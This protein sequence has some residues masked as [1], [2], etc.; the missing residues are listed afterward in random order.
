MNRSLLASVS[1]TWWHDG[2]GRN[3]MVGMH[4]MKI[5]FVDWSTVARAVVARYHWYL[6][7]LVIP[8][9]PQQSKIMKQIMIAPAV[10]ITMGSLDPDGV[11]RVRAWFDYLQRW[12][13]DEVVRKNSVPLEKIPGVYVMRTTTDIRIFFRIDGDTIT[14]LDVAR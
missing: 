11:R 8:R 12:D 3:H 1:A 6:R 9:N 4:R 13:E 10:E 14:V 5:A 2:R 7:L